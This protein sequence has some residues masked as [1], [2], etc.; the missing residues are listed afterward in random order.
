MNLVDGL[1]DLFHVTSDFLLWHRFASFQLMVQLTSRTYL[2]DN[3]NVGLVIEVT[4][5]L[6]D[7]WI[8]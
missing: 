3:V 5:H 8:I 4:V 2:Q 7:V 6:D 1:T